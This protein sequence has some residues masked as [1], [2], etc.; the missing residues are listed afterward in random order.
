MMMA[1]VKQEHCV[2]VFFPQIIFE[3][4]LLYTGLSSSYHHLVIAHY[5]SRV[6]RIELIFDREVHGSSGFFFTYH[7][8]MLH[9]VEGIV[10]NLST[11]YLPAVPSFRQDMHFPWIL[12]P[13]W[14]MDGYL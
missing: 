8:M 9:S 1:L 6:S 7:K 10:I 13:H 4:P 14:Q 5:F 2:A 12:E 11:P 3:F